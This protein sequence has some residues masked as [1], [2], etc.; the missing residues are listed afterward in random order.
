MDPSTGGTCG[1]SLYV[2]WGY[3]KVQPASSKSGASLASGGARELFVL[4]SG[5]ASSSGT[6]G[7]VTPNLRAYDRIT[8]T[9]L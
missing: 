9:I 4:S 8:D 2:D 1:S 3:L 7:Y 5:F 6:D